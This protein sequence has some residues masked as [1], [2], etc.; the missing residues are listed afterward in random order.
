MG[1]GYSYLKRFL[2]AEFHLG[3]RGSNVVAKFALRNVAGFVTDLWRN[4]VQN[5]AGAEHPM[6]GDGEILCIQ[7]CTAKK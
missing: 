6:V 2:L 4:G 5:S 3:P 7:S 1:M